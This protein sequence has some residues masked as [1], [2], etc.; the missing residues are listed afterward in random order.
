MPDP[1]TEPRCLETATTVL[2]DG[3]NGVCHAPRPGAPPCDRLLLGAEIALALA[4]VIVAP[5]PLPRRRLALAFVAAVAAAATLPG[6]SAIATTRA[7]APLNAVAT[8]AP[9]RSLAASLDRFARAHPRCVRVVRNDCIACEPIVR[10]ALPV[11]GH[12]TG[13][14]GLVTLGPDAL[15]ARC[16]VSRDALV[17]GVAA[18]PPGS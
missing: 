7:D 1:L 10:F 5:W 15:E 9:M 11:R 6:L 16:A 2:V 8:V 4:V 3:A 18:P 12:C 13:A 14:W 17:C